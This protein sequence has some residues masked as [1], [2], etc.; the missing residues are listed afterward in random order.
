MPEPATVAPE[1]PYRGVIMSAACIR[2]IC[3]EMAAD[4]NGSTVSPLGLNIFQ[5]RMI[6]DRLETIAVDLM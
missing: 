6:A 3:D 5:L 1:E 4:C 2:A